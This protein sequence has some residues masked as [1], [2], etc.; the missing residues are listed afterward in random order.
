M[1]AKGDQVATSD[2]AAAEKSSRAAGRRAGDEIQAHARKAL[3]E[4]EYV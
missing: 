2:L 4:I 3:L 1:E